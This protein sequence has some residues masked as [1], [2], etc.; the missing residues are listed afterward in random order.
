MGEEKE[1][2]LRGKVCAYLSPPLALVAE[3]TFA[4]SSLGPMMTKSLYIT[5]RRLSS[6]LSATYCFS[7][8]GACTSATSASPFAASASAR[9]VPRETV[10]TEYPSVFQRAE[11][12]HRAIQNP[13][14]SLSWRRNK[15]LQSRTV[16][17][18]PKPKLVQCKELP[19][20]KAAWRGRVIGLRRSRRKG[21]RRCSR[22]AESA[23]RE[24]FSA[25]RTRGLSVRIYA[26]TR[27]RRALAF[28]RYS[29]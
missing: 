3:R 12:K 18:A 10:L 2:L 25:P 9:P 24:S 6:F 22:P 27:S 1:I 20:G 13:E 23:Q 29:S 26:K 5:K 15:S 17:D 19:G 21:V 16:G 14:C 4:G 11:P 8:L 28:S 7:R